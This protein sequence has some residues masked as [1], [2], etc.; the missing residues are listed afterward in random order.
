MPWLTTGGATTKAKKTTNMMTDAKMIATA[1][2]RD[3]FLRRRAST[4]GFK[5]VARN[6]AI[7]INTNIWLTLASARINTIAVNTPKVAIKP[8]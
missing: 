6:R 1:E 3:K 7:R 4:A 2:A 5:P 8:K